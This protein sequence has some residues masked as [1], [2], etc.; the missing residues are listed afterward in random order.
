[1]N[2]DVVG[3][4]VLRAL[5][6]QGLAL[7]CWVTVVALSY[8]AWRRRRGNDVSNLLIAGGLCLVVRLGLLAAGLPSAGQPGGD[9]LA[10]ALDLTGLLLVAWPFL[11]PPLPTHWA[12]RLAGVGLAAVAFACSL[13]LWQWVRGML[14]L[15]PTHQFTITWAHAALALAGL[16]ALNLLHARVRRRDWLLTATGAL[17]AGISGLLT[18]PP[19]TPP[20]SAVLTAATAAF[21]AAWLNWLECARRKATHTTP[22]S[23]VY[24]DPQSRALAHLV[25]R[26]ELQ[27]KRLRAILDGLPDGII[28]SNAHDR[29]VMTNS[30]ALDILGKERSDVIGNP[31]GQVAGGL[32]PAGDSGAVDTLI[33]ASSA[34]VKVL[35][36]VADRIVQ[37]SMAPVKN[38]GG[39]QAGVV[40]VLR[41]ITAQ[42]KAEAKIEQQLAGLQECT[43]QLED[44]AEQLRTLDRFKSQ[45]IANMSHEL[46]TPLNSILGFSGMILK[47]I[48]GQLTE[49]QRQDI[50]AIHTSGKH[51]LKL[52]TD[53]LDISQ[54]WTGKM[55]LTLGNVNLPE[56]VESAIAIVAPLIG[57]R[58]L[59]L[60]QAL[61]SDL[62]VVRADKTRVRQVLLNL[63]T[64]AIKYTERG[65]VTISASRD[66][67]GVVIR[68]ADT[69]IG[70][71]PEH[72]GTIFEASS[73]LNRPSTQRVD[74]LGLGLSISRQLVELQGGQ[75]WV[76][77]E[78]GVGS[79]F[80]FSLPIEGPPSNPTDR[81]IT[82]Q[83]LE[84]ALTRWK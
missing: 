53:M 79:T 20:L 63:L 31:F 23:Q 13:S 10:T 12:D 47:G 15:S 18:S 1:M 37:T 69:G 75:I 57:D 25:R 38:N 16:A 8:A 81:K 9:W 82:H 41:D 45:F 3:W 70:I 78:V 6:G 34:G 74:G 80:Y 44:T 19:V 52:I 42:A 43:R 66:E 60:V 14:G 51:L 73:R 35:F 56:I 17:L 64:N 84:V 77:S 61:D 76:D 46:R 68:V 5:P 50:E 32:A 72:L 26:Q 2:N 40:T 83:Q 62:P 27:T 71:P 39:T 58:P 21:A 4:Q 11:A 29:V 28:V 33:E 24:P 30:A 49:T 7:L 36:E 48:D 22:R 67:G 65:R 59:E 55:D 54:L